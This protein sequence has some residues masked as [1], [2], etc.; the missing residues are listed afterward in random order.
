MI[1][2][3]Y[4]N[5]NLLKSEPAGWDGFITTI[6]RDYDIKGLLKT[7]DAT[8]TFQGDGYTYLRTLFE[9]SGFCE[10]IE[11]IIDKSNDYGNNW[12]QFFIGTIFLTQVEWD[13]K[14]RY[15]KCKLQDDSYYA[16]INNNKSQEVFLYA[17][18]SKNGSSITPA[19]LIDVGLFQIATGSYISHSY[20]DFTKFYSVHEVFRYLIDYMTDLKVGFKSDIFSTGLWK[21]LT[22]TTGLV[23]SNI[24]ADS[25]LIEAD[26]KDSLPKISFSKFI[27]EIGHLDDLWFGIERDS[28]GSPVFRLEDRAYFFDD[29]NVVLQC[30]KIDELLTKT[31]LNRL[32]SRLEIGSSETDD[33]GTFPEQI[34]LRGFKKE[35]YNMIGQCNIDKTLDLS[36]DYIISSNVIEAVLAAGGYDDKIF[37][38]DTDGAGQAKQSNWLGIGSE[39][40]YNESL[41]NENCAQRFLKAIPNTIAEYLGPVID[42]RFKA[43]ATSDASFNQNTS[44]TEAPVQFDDDYTFPN[45]DVSNSFGN[46]TTQGSPV[47]GSDS[48]FTTNDAGQFIFESKIDIDCI[49]ISRPDYR[50]SFFYSV[51]GQPPP[52]FVDGETITYA[53][54]QTAIIYKVSGT[55]LYLTNVT[56]IITLNNTGVTFTGGTSG[57]TGTTGPAINPLKPYTLS[58]GFIMFKTVRYDS[59]NSLVENI[60]LVVKPWSIG[61]IS[62]M[63][64]KTVNLNAGDYI[65]REIIFSNGDPGII[66]I[67]WDIKAFRYFSCIAS[68]TGGVY[69]TYNTEDYAALQHQFEYELTEDQFATI[70]N[71]PRGFI[72]FCR[73]EEKKRN[74]WI[75]QI[76]FYHQQAKA[77]FLLNSSKSI[78]K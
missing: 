54:I 70:Q 49:A 27:Q 10:L 64:L 71:N 39:V 30:G 55:T 26:F 44:H 31:D 77:K 21:G 66:N 7:Q 50:L 5:G 32:F 17:G 56:D 28:S 13:E 37:I 46:G 3:Y 35:D 1:Y 18:Q 60:S 23:I 47:A 9:A 15:A 73:F 11:I 74:G 62:D 24:G 53:G 25:N 65:T 2:R 33:S 19:A 59:S 67:E 6:K 68:A 72:N 22:I 16:R 36:R 43:V 78:N 75:E 14:R 8:I 63:V 20:T 4:L 34:K 69:K 12:R 51:F 38:I 58:N 61:L 42:Y 41:T 40:Y 48:R 29:K 52:F 57:A 76:Q 45:N